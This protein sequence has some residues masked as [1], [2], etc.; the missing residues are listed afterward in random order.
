MKKETDVD[1]ILTSKPHLLRL[2][3]LVNY[4]QIPVVC[5][6][7]QVAKTHPSVL[8]GT[9]NSDEK[10]ATA[11]PEPPQVKNTLNSFI[12]FP[13]DLVKA[14]KEGKPGKDKIDAQM[15]LFS[16]VVRYRN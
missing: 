15:H 12:L 6:C 7:Y 14:T 4:K 11:E 10:E 3:E 8:V 5:I 13:P 16:H 2:T 1:D 9:A